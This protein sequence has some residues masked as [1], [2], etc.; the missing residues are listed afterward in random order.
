MGLFLVAQGDE[1]A[2]ITLE[3]EAKV[4]DEPKVLFK[5][6]ESIKKFLGK[7]PV[8]VYDPKNLRDPMIVPWIRDE[9]LAQEI[10][11]EA[12]QLLKENKLKE[13]KLK[14]D[15]VFEKY[16]KTVQVKEAHELFIKIEQM[17]KDPTT[18]EGPDVA[19]LPDWIKNETKGALIDKNEAESLALI[20]SHILKKGEIV[21][22]SDVIIKSIKKDCIIYL[23][24]GKEF[25]VYFD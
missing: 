12:N 9:V 18:W 25:K 15:E 14:V 23:H 2:D 5:T 22:N 10:I 6:E 1:N 8:F 21:P 11:S 7:S 24:R 13:A 4:S 17:I 16:P 3:K 20:G 19:K